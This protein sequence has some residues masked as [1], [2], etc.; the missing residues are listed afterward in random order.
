[1]QIKKVL[2]KTGHETKNSTLFNQKLNSIQ[3]YK[4]KIVMSSDLKL[5]KRHSTCRLLKPITKTL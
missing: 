4:I 3:I 2:R 1:M 5:R